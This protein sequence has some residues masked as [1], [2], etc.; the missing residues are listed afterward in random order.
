MLG[1]NILMASFAVVMREL[2]VPNATVFCGFGVT[3][4]ESCVSSVFVV[5]PSSSML[6]DLRE[7]CS[8]LS[9]SGERSHFD[10]WP[11]RVAAVGVACSRFASWVS[12]AAEYADY[13][14]A[15][16]FDSVKGCRLLPLIGG[17]WGGDPSRKLL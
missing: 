3:G 8:T 5:S 6:R 9:P 7:D 14:L 15:P 16:N 17:S 13:R 10:A 4:W 11:D 1:R 2:G 12:N